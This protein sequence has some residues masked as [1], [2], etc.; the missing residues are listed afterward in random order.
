MRPC[1]LIIRILFK[2]TINAFVGA[3]LVLVLLGAVFA[4]WTDISFDPEGYMWLGCNCLATAAYVLY[5]RE[6][7]KTPLST[8]DKAFLNNALT[9]PLG[10]I[11]GA[12]IGDVSFGTAP[13]PPAYAGVATLSITPFIEA[14]AHGLRRSR[15]V[16][17]LRSSPRQHFWS[18]WC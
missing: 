4:G 5:M 9:I 16:S 3:S 13:C 8:W 1:V 2:E 12:L 11:M 7:V 18:H 15:K 17:P 10:L 14:H 6:T